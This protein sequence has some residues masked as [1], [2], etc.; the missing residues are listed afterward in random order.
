M[1]W[2]NLIGNI[3]CWFKNN[4]ISASYF[5]DNSYK[6]INY[7]CFFYVI[8][9]TLKNAC[10]V[11]KIDTK[12]IY[13]FCV[14]Y[15]LCICFKHINWCVNN[16]VEIES[17]KSIM[18]IWKLVLLVVWRW[19]WTGS[20]EVKAFYRFWTWLLTVFGVI[21]KNFSRNCFFRVDTCSKMI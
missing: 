9:T 3:M 4:C 1:I 5:F 13:F 20:M 11:C 18:Q 21:L 2:I 8:V 15:N 16:C 14:C 19:S 7:K 17:E 6:V 12:F 10:K